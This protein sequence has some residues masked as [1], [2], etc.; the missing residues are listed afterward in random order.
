MADSHGCFTPALDLIAT[1]Q[2]RVM[3]HDNEGLLDALVKVRHPCPTDCWS[4]QRAYQLGIQLKAVVDQLPYVFH[5]ISVNP[6][7]GENFAHPV[8]WGQRYA[9]FSAPLS[10]RVPALSGLFLPL[11]Q[12][13]ICA[14]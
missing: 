7:S 11:F 12:A 3:E 10:A 8:E 2:E 9:K 5:K 6:G 14:P 1:C 13:S 4:E